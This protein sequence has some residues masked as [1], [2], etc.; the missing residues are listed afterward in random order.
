MTATETPVPAVEPVL[1]RPSRPRPR[2]TARWTALAVGAV[3]AVFV[4]VLATRPPA[5]DVI[6][7]SPLLGLPAPPLQGPGLN[8]GTLDLV[9]LRGRY[10]VVNFFATWCVPCLKEHPE[11]VK[12][13]D[14]HA[15]DDAQVMAVI[16]DDDIDGV[17]EFF[18][19]EGGD[20]PVVD[21]SGAKVD[22][23]VRAVPESFLVDPNGV[24]LT[25]LVGGVTADGLD[26][27]LT[28]A[29]AAVR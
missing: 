5:I 16:Y 25:R 6:A 24:V 18:K 19:K 12:F 28:R 10:V 17:R 14:R 3:V 11:L 13:A 4:A 26:D 20:W 2:R 7:D 15:T 8:G 9:D 23:G 21:D 29:K 1:P 22:W 27:L